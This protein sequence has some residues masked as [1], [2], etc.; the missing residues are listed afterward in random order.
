M[1]FNLSTSLS[2]GDIKVGYIDPTLGYVSGITICEANNYAKDN[3]GTTFIFRDGD[4]NIRYLNINEVNNL[5]VDN[6]V[7]TATT[8]GGIQEYQECG[9][10]TIQFFGGDGVGASANPVVGVDGSLLAVDVVSGGFGYKYSPSV[11]AKDNCQLGS[12]AVLVAVLGETADETEVYEGEDE[13]EEYQLCDADDIGYGNIYGSDGEILGEWDPNPYTVVGED[14]IKREIEIYQ[15]ALEKPFWTTRKYLPDR[16][17]TV[18]EDFGIVYPVDDS[19]YVDRMKAGGVT[20]PV[21]WGEFMNTHAVSPVPPSDLS[22]S[23]FSGRVFTMEWEQNFPI[24]GEYLFRGVSDNNSQVY[25]DNSLVGELKDF[26]QNPSPISKT[27]EEGNHVIRIDLLNIPIKGKVTVDDVYEEIDFS[28]YGQGGDVRDVLF[29]FTSEDGRD[30]F[31]IPGVNKNKKSRVDKLTVRKNT[32]Y[33]VKAKENS[34]VHKSVEQGLIINGTKAKESGEGTSNKIFADYVSSKNDNDDIQVSVNKGIFTSSNRRK[35][36]NSTRNTYDLTFIL[37]SDTV[38]STKEI[39]S[40][41]SWNENPM[42]VALTIEAPMPTIPK[43]QPPVQTGRCPPNPIWST[44]FPGSSQTWYPVRYTKNNAWSKFMN[45]YAISPV[46]P[47]DTPGSDISGTTFTNSWDVDLPYAGFYGVKG[48]RDNRGRVLIDNVE[49]S[50][51]DGFDVENPGLKKVYLTK[52][53]H[54]ITVEILNRPVETT[55]VINTKIFSTRDWR[56]PVPTSST[57]PSAPAAAGPSNVTA[58]FIK[59]GSSFYLQVDGSGSA[60]ISFVM[61]VNDAYYLAGLAAKQ[62]I[63]PA[64]D[65]KKIKFTRTEGLD[66]VNAKNQTT[67]QST[68]VAGN[69]VTEEVLKEK[70]TFTAG[71]KYGPIEIIGADPLAKGPI[72][73]KPNRLGIRDAEGDDENIKITI[74]EIKPIVSS[75][76]TTAPAPA[77]FTVSNQTITKDGVTYS[78]PEIFGYNDTRWSSFMNEYSVSPKVFGSISSPEPTV[79]GQYT[80]V[81]KQVN[82]PYSG[83]YKL[84]FQADNIATLKIG[85]NQLYTVTDFVGDRIDNTFNITSG[86]YDIE[87]VLENIQSPDN[88]GRDTIFSNN[89]LGVSLYISKDVSFTETNKTS[90]TDNPVAVSAI[91]IPPPCAKKIGGKGVIE[92]V[93]V[94]DPGNGYLPPAQGTYPALLILEEVLVDSPGINYRCGEDPIQIVPDNGAKLSYTCDSFGRITEVKVEV[95]GSPFTVYPQ[96]SIPSETGVNASFRPVFRV[97][98]D[99]AEA[100]VA[101]QQDLQEKL[102]QVTDLVGLKQTG[103]VD[104]R[105]YY[106]AVYYD[107]GVR[108]AGYYRTAGTQVRVY[109]TLQESITARVTT[110]PSAIQRSGTD[111]RS[112]DPRLN[113]PGTPQS[114]TE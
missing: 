19:T 53:R 78:G 47:L 66:S 75:T 49:V 23:D 86:K 100:L 63:I 46:L 54:T 32:L 58:K 39:I 81:W 51:L 77:A 44:R 37:N 21:R 107:E 2:D 9:P 42:G 5:T 112:N 59:K 65:N 34:A 114:T 62:V 31:I 99:P 1:F 106:G 60:E 84:N 3:P 71:Q 45:R 85:G 96:I 76:P 102:I 41:K 90:W 68:F 52:G 74:S 29:T 95:P 98:R 35:A 15:K 97:V 103:Y 16:V 20:N 28:V 18:D 92:K 111:I 67:G 79:V 43:E 6:I 30:T 61:D 26:S 27:I 17:I 110:P 24:T 64:N 83:T 36:K 14:P 4:N 105:A 25:I 10:P 82:F 7:S 48:T 38:A 22:G 72:I 109:D 94:D 40:A 93:Y 50:T 13:F 73:N 33:K 89:P 88:D 101:E 56:A 57:T 113:I 55:S 70:G 80:M 87:V 8:C 12:G 11:Q 108:Y 69:A 91:L 104:G